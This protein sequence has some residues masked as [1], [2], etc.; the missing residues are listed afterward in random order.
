MKKFT[1]PF[2]RG[3]LSF[4]APLGMRVDVAQSS[5]CPPIRK[6]DAAIEQAFRHPTACKPLAKLALSFRRA[7]ITVTDI[8]RNCPDSV[9]LPIIVRHLNEGGISDKNITVLVA[10]GIHRPMTAAEHRTKYGME[11][12]RRL[13]ILNHDASNS[14]TNISMGT[15]SNG[16]PVVIDAIVHEAAE[17]KDTLLLATGVVE[18]HQYAGYS[19]GGKTVSIGC[20]GME[21][22]A[23]T[24]GIRFI[25]APGTRLGQIARNPFQKAM[26]EIGRM[27]SLRFIV[28]V[29]LDDE[30][31]MLAVRA[32]DPIKAHDQL[33]AFAKTVYETEV[34]CQCDIVVAG[35]GFPKD[36]NLY[37]A[38]RAAS[39]LVFAP[40]P[41]V[42]KGG[43]I[44]L[45]ARCAEGAGSG[46]GEREFLKALS[47][48]RTMDELIAKQH[49][50][51]IKPGGQRA[52][53]MAKVLKHCRV[54]VAGSEC[55]EIVAKLHMIPAKDIRDAI[56][57][58]QG[59]TSKPRMLVVPHA[60]LT[61]PIVRGSTR[62]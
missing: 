47:S 29:V 15:T 40:K 58:A 5:P 60:L 27:A 12:A 51:G 26:R 16:V 45:P 43:F 61:L 14:G 18:P 21:T 41:V 28:N 30:G 55:P 20:A 33:V 2:D 23:D 7:V 1:V 36:A 24:H 54:I 8:T 46:A 3:T 49:K 4:T 39:Y 13:R 25:D 32:G 38:S 62:R 57:I 9:L 22:I 17:S 6:A 42:R 59:E 52:Y 19:G 35:V 31:R 44:I 56:G 37:Q 10:T 48:V 50:E 53:V 11:I 34:P